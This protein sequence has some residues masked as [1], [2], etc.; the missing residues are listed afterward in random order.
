MPKRPLKTRLG[1]QTLPEQLVEL[2]G[3]GLKV[4]RGVLGVVVVLLVQVHVGHN[5]KL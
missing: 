2:V 3:Q 5:I 1:T 4:E